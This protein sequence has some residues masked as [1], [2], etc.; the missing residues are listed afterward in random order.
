MN[1]CLRSFKYI[2]LII[3]M[4][5]CGDKVPLN[6]QGFDNGLSNLKISEKAIFDIDDRKSIEDETNFFWKNKARSIFAIMETKNIH[7]IGSSYY[8]FPNTLRSGGYYCPSMGFMDH[9]MLPGAVCT[10][11]LI[12]PTLAVTAG[13]CVDDMY[14]VDENGKKTE[15]IIKTAQDVCKEKSFI[16]DYRTDD[17]STQSN[18]FKKENVYSCKRL[19]VKKAPGETRLIDAFYNQGSDFALIELDRPVVGRGSLIINT[20]DNLEVGTSLTTI[21]H[22]FGLPSI[23]SQG[24]T[25]IRKS[26]AYIQTDLDILGGSSGGPVFNE[27]GVVEA[28]VASELNIRYYDSVNKCTYLRKLEKES[29]ERTP[30]FCNSATRISEVT[31]AIEEL[32]AR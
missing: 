21:G 8:F 12:S 27:A 24:G 28:I 17:L 1:F 5:G 15:E 19:I 32:N 6:E 9:K 11:F 2:F 4:M 7:D 14:K 26:D 16:F 31:K 25:M 13:H 20:H 3:M 23:I 18:E 10:G 29:C 30:L 22:P